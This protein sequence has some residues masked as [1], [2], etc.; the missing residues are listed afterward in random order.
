MIAQPKIV[1]TNLIVSSCS[2]L[3]GWLNQ[4]RNAE[5]RRSRSYAGFLVMA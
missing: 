3:R 4:P 2:Y 1:D 5:F